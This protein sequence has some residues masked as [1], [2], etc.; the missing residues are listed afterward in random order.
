MHLYI[1]NEF[2]ENR[3]FLENCG[4]NSNVSSSQW[5]R[6]NEQTEQRRKNILVKKCSVDVGLRNVS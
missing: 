4:N 2:E 6:K 1:F 5:D 3:K